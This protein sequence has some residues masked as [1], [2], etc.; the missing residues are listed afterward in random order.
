M[1]SLL[2][3]KNSDTGRTSKENDT[4]KTNKVNELL[5]KYKETNPQDIL[6]Q[7]YRLSADHITT[8]TLG[9]Q[10]E[11][12]D[13]KVQKLIDIFITEGVRN[14]FLFYPPCLTHIWKMIFTDF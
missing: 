9:L 5:N 4:E 2:N 14:S 13:E 7:N 6:T 1:K 8:L 10:P 11:E 12:H 3:D